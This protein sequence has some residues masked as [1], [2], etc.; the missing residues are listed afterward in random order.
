[1]DD[2]P[3]PGKALETTGLNS[4]EGTILPGGDETTELSRLWRDTLS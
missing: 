3:M 2:S 1:M 4:A